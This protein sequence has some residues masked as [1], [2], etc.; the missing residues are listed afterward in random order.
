LFDI[1][2]KFSPDRSGL[3]TAAAVKLWSGG[4]IVLYFAEKQIINS[5]LKYQAMAPPRAV[6]ISKDLEPILTLIHFAFW[7]PPAYSD[8]K[9]LSN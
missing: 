7:S 1:G 3:Q 5:L 6:R 4:A 8:L 9:T 2:L